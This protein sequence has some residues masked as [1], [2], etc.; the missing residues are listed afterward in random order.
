M[1]LK[2]RIAEK[3]AALVERRPVT[4]PKCGEAVVVRGLMN[5]E[6]SRVNAAGEELRGLAVICLATE[7]PETPG[8][9]L[10]NWALQKDRDAAG[11]LHTDDAVAIITAHNELAGLS[12]SPEELLKNSDRTESSLTSSPS[13]T[14]SS[15]AS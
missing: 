2:D 9:P 6:M 11:A 8:R 4:L 5:A 1:S 13:D 12:E 7:D 15:P 14:E 10:W 3:S